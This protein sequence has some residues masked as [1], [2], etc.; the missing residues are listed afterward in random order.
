MPIAIAVCINSS[1]LK[2]DTF[3][4][5]FNSTFSCLM[6]LLLVFWPIKI[7]LEFNSVIKAC[8]EVREQDIYEGGEVETKVMKKNKNKKNKKS[9][10]NKSTV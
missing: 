10:K 7:A 8:T 4:T 2:F 5:G 9:K 3:G 6:G 1:S